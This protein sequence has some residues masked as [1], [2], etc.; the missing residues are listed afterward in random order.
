MVSEPTV[1]PAE[2][3]SWIGRQERQ[4]EVVSERL[5]AAFN[6]TLD[7]DPGTPR[8][9]DPAPLA[10]HWCLAPHL[11]PA[12]EL[13]P[14]GHP[15]RGGFLPPVPLPSRMWAGGQLQFV[16]RLRVGDT[17]RRTATIADIVFK[18]GRSGPLC[19][20]TVDIAVETDRSPA[21]R[22]RQDVV[23]RAGRPGAGAPTP[24]VHPPVRAS[25]TMQADAVLLFR[26][27]ALIFNAHRIHFDRA[28]C[29]DQEGYPG[30]VVH[31]PLMA[32]LLIDFAASLGGEGLTS[33]DYRGVSPLFDGVPF[34]LNAADT[35][36]GLE[37]WI[38][39]A[40]GRDIMTATASW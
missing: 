10:I 38:S 40:D 35:D 28:Y 27:S 30:L 4:E 17:A 23:Y 20:V 5:V 7:R 1:D 15:K 18:Q 6:A 12:G 31:A 37:L 32:T 36:D 34:S 29:V 13:G 39:V 3:R 2:F 25:R 19:F 33:F 8:P 11:V 26:Y 22:E 24:A 21:I 14:D 9:G 16:D